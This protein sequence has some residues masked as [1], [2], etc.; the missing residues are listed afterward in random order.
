MCD[1]DVTLSWCCSGTSDEEVSSM[2]DEVSVLRNEFVL[3]WRNGLPVNGEHQTRL[4]LNYTHELTII[5]VF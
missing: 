1:D 2:S 3:D 4:G 5:R